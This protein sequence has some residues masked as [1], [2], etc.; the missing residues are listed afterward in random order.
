MK[1]HLF[2]IMGFKSQTVCQKYHFNTHNVKERK[3]EVE[4][5]TDQQI[6]WFKIHKYNDSGVKNK[7][8]HKKDERIRWFRI[9]RKNSNW[10][11]VI[12]VTVEVTCVN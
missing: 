8:A 3:D 10:N 12:M 7:I 5:Y 11:C 4:V 1:I 9:V 6:K 2:Y